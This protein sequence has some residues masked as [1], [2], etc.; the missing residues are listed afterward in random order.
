MSKLTKLQKAI[1]LKEQEILSL[2]K[3]LTETKQE[4]AQYKKDSLPPH[5]AELFDE[6]DLL[7]ISLVIRKN[8]DK[9]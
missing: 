4:L 3:A 8:N 6:E 5:L 1:K 2:Q 9:M 7:D